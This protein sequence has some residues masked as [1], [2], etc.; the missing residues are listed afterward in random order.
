MRNGSSVVV[1]RCPFVIMTRPSTISYANSS[2]GCRHGPAPNTSG[3]RGD[4][5]PPCRPR[6]K[7]LQEAQRRQRDNLQKQIRRAQARLSSAERKQRT[8]RLILL[9]SYL[10][11]VT[12]E[13]PG[14][15]DSLTQGLDGFLERARDRALFDLPPAPTKTAQPGS[16]PACAGS[17]RPPRSGCT[18]GQTRSRCFRRTLKAAAP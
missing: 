1:P 7:E 4:S 8:R 17:R 18:Y 5:P 14:K 9:G 13:D 6:K 3:A 2:P 10:E 11:Y 15:R 16:A 12:G